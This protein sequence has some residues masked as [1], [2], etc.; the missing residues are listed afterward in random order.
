MNEHERLAD[1]L[2]LLQF[3]IDAIP[4]AVYWITM[5]GRIS[6][7]NAAACGMLG[8]SREEFLCLSVH[9]I[10]PEYSREDVPS[11]TDKLKRTGILH[12]KR[13][14]TAKD[15]RVIPVE[16]TSNYFVYNDAEYICCI[17]HDITERVRAEMEAAFFRTL[18]ECTSDPVYV[19]RYKDPCRMSY[20]NEAACRHFGMDR[21]QVVS[22]HLPDWDPVFDAEHIE[23]F[24]RELRNNKSV[25]FETMHRVA[26]GD[27][28]PVEVTANYLE[29]DGEELIAGYF[30]DISRRRSMEAALRQ[31]QE[32]LEKRIEERTVGLRDANE[33]LQ[34]EIT[35]RER[36]ERVI[37]ARLR[38]LQFA[39]THTL[40]ELLEATLNEAEALTGSLIGFFHF[41]EADQE[42]LSPQNWSTRTKAE[43]C[44][45]KV[46]DS[47]ASCKRTCSLLNVSSETA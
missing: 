28:V 22:L 43:F 10:D 41:L 19:S 14:H 3:S 18:I 1:K 17:V 31:A 4:D 33:L 32:E 36:T 6:N 8:Y 40:D 24:I 26:S 9:D 20:V 13:R 47:R 25:R 37:M 23:E 29:L 46:K 7:V 39:A 38:L 42:T 27:L 12:L 44:R 15:G 11:D 5:D 45:V 34:Q 2:N 21:R 16:I 35:V 30:H